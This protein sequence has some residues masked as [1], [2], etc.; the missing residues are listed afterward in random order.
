M[1][2]QRAMYCR[3]KRSRLE[4]SGQGGYFSLSCVILRKSLISDSQGP[5]RFSEDLKKKK[6][7]LKNAP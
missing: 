4:F 6:E 5:Q 1:T 3:S 7:Y 2:V